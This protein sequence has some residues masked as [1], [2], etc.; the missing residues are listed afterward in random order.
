LQDK[1]L[2]AAIGDQETPS[3]IKE[4]CDIAWASQGEAKD[5][6]ILGGHRIHDFLVLLLLSPRQ[7]STVAVDEAQAG[8][9][10]TALDTFHDKGDAFLNREGRGFPSDVEF[11]ER[12]D[13]RALTN[14]RAYLA[15]FGVVGSKSHGPLQ[16]SGRNS[17]EE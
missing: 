15:K 1:G 13:G 7:R 9:A 11:S 5:R 16:K 4:V 8:P 2:A 14:S 10:V 6:N 12:G 3:W 17:E